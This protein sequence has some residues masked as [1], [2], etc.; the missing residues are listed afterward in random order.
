MVTPSAPGQPGPVTPVAVT[1]VGLSAEDR[2]RLAVAFRALLER[3]PLPLEPPS[4]PSKRKRPARPKKPK[5]WFDELPKSVQALLGI[6]GAAILAAVIG[7]G[8]TAAL[9][10]PTVQ[11]FLLG[12][13][14]DLAVAPRLRSIISSVR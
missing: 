7:Y 11:G 1:D 14:L 10:G 5:N 9:K 13:M 2:A 3:T 12:A 6:I 4:R 8:I